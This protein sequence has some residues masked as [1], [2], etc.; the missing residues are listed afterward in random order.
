MNLTSVEIIEIKKIKDK[1]FD[2]TCKLSENFEI[3]LQMNIFLYRDKYEVECCE[4]KKIKKDN[5]GFI[6]LIVKTSKNILSEHFLYNNS[7]KI[8]ISDIDRDNFSNFKLEKKKNIFFSII[9]KLALNKVELILKENMVNSAR[10]FTLSNS[11]LNKIKGFKII[12]SKFGG[13]PALPEN[14]EWPKNNNNY[15]LSFIGQLNLSDFKNLET[16]KDFKN[17]GIIYFFLELGNDGAS[18]PEYRNDSYKVIYLNKLPKISK[19]KKLPI[20]LKDIKALREVYFGFIQEINVPN[21]DSNIIKDFYKLENLEKEN[22]EYIEEILNYFNYTEILSHKLLGYPQQIQGC[23]AREC[24][25]STESI[26]LSR[27]EKDQEWILLFQFCCHDYNMKM[28]NQVDVNNEELYFM[29]KREDLK[30]NDFEKTK[31]IIQ[32]T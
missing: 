13:L 27:I 19:T 22:Y 12:N 17:E 16:T 8:F 23:V 32:S 21:S 3:S 24:Y 2:L 18:Y 11:Q 6:N 20:E 1:L 29:I 10:I 26:K 30:N 14:I 15:P 31:L 7:K 9:E 25:D 4:I 5:N 28:Y